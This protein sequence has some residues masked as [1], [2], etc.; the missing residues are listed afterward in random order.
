MRIGFDIVRRQDV[1][2]C[3]RVGPVGLDFRVSGGNYVGIDMG[4]AGDNRHFVGIV[5]LR[6]NRLIS[7]TGAHAFRVMRRRIGIVVFVL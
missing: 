7:D 4:V 6:A 5:F 1:C 2:I 3:I